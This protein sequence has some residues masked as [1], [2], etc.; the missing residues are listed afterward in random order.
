MDRGTLVKGV[1]RLTSCSSL[2]GLKVVPGTKE[3]LFYN[4]TEGFQ[5]TSLLK[6]DKS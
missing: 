1:G 3:Y 2:L 4:L 5:E 6:S